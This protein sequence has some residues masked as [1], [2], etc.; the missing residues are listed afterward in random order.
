M[1]EVIKLG[2]TRIRHSA[3]AFH[4]VKEIKV[5]W[6]ETK[7]IRR[8]GNKAK[9]MDEQNIFLQFRD[10]RSI[11]DARGFLLT[12]SHSCE[13]S[14]DFMQTQLSTSARDFFARDEPG[15]LRGASGRHSIEEGGECLW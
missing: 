15:R 12:G 9:S 10:V 2:M 1:I 13:I 4:V 11:V 8:V 14:I 3:I 7:I 5:K 6:N